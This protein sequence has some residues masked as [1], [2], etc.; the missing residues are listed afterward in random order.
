[1]EHTLNTSGESFSYVCVTVADSPLDTDSALDEP[2]SNY[3]S[4]TFETS[5]TSFTRPRSSSAN[6]SMSGITQVTD[7]KDDSDF[8]VPEKETK[9]KTIS[10]DVEIPLTFAETLRLICSLG[11]KNRTIKRRVKIT[12]VDESDEEDR[13]VSFRVS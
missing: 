5:E 8:A 6:S 3:L 9:F 12:N 2:K 1:M 10:G 4:P 7:I 13:E 11:K